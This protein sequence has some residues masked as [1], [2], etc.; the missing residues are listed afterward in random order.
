MPQSPEAV[1]PPRATQSSAY[2]KQALEALTAASSPSALFAEIE[3]YYHGSILEPAQREL[4]AMNRRL[5]FLRSSALFAA[6]ST[7]AY[8]NEFLEATL[9]PRDAQELD[10][11]SP[12]EKLMIG[13]RL[14]GVRPALDRGGPPLQRLLA[15]FAVRNALVHPRRSGAKSVSA[16][17]QDVSDRDKEL[18]GPRAASEYVIAV[19]EMAVLLEPYRLGPSVIGEAMRITEDRAV[20]TTHRELLGDEIL[21]IP[22]ADDAEPIP[23]LV[24]MQRRASARA[25]S[26]KSYGS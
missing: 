8:A 15:L 19:A 16:Y 1:R 5:G 3:D 13:S 20:L 23:L 21:V 18:V 7:E 11:L 9:P 17:V 26:D 22:S 6:L 24:Q 10:R 4:S 25:S 14:V 12:P 2:L